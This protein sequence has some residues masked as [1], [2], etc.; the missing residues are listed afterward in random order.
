MK[1]VI[2]AGGFGTRLR[3]VI[4]R[5]KCLIDV[6]D[7]KTILDHQVELLRHGG[8]SNIQLSLHHDADA[9]RAYARRFGAGVST[10]FEPEPLGTGGAVKHATRGMREPVLVFN[11][12]ILSDLD[13]KVF[14]THALENRAHT[15]ALIPA[16]AR[17]FGNVELAGDRVVGFQ[18]KAKHDVPQWISLGA[19]VLFPG[20]F[21]CFPDEFSLEKVCFPLLAKRGKLRAYFHQGKF[22]DVGTPERFEKRREVFG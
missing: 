21:E 17:D 2:L 11:G 4:D 1:A 15:L 22:L 16:S 5:P 8:I 9:V 12:D 14:F 3:G 19:Y 20:I 10:V 13:V 18:E 7:G 6:G